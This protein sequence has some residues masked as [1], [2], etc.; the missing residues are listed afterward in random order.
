MTSAG[1]MDCSVWPKP[2]LNVGAQQ[3]LTST[4]GSTHY[5]YLN[6]KGGVQ[7]SFRTWPLRYVIVHQGCIYYFRNSS[8]ITD[9][10]TP[11]ILFPFKLVHGKANCR[12]WL[13]SASNENER[14]IWMAV[15][16]AEIEKYCQT[17]SQKRDCIGS[18]FYDDIEQPLPFSQNSDTDEYSDHDYLE[19]DEFCFGYDST[20]I[21]E[22]DISHAPTPDSVNQDI[23]QNKIPKSTK[24][25]QPCIPIKPDVCHPV[26]PPNLIP[27]I[28]NAVKLNM[29][30]EHKKVIQAPTLDAPVRE[31]LSNVPMSR[32]LPLLPKS[33][34]LK[35]PKPPNPAVKP[36]PLS[37]KPNIHKFAATQ[38]QEKCISQKPPLDVDI[39]KPSEEHLPQPRKIPLLPQHMKSTLSRESPDGQ[40]FKREF[41]ERNTE[42]E[43][44]Q[45]N[46]K[47]LKSIFMN[48]TSSETVEQQMHSVKMVNGLF[49]IR[50]SSTRKE[51]ILVVWDEDHNK[52][53]NFII[54]QHE[55]SLTLD[56]NGTWFHNLL[57]LLQFYK[58][59]VLPLQKKD[60]HLTRPLIV[61]R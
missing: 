24:I 20:F 47:M 48:T 4:E 59:N 22:T 25:Q 30:V 13:F 50:N 46:E 37:H 49:C 40:S 36:K 27:E 39:F 43:H 2:L 17:K 34:I 15:V 26:V 45:L 23:H 5:G 58:E 53:R 12:T 28:K 9:E 21:N 44:T 10:Q 41:M 57:E 8:S 3:L 6:K 18:G 11:E 56:K 60:L 52:V 29:Q 32:V 31:I 33:V 38:T 55:S 19:P 51:Q 7:I 54:F 42:D 35:P 14:K 16:K 61:P 1:S